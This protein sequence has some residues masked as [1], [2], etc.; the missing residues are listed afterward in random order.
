MEFNAQTTQLDRLDAAQRAAWVEDGFLIARQLFSA[1]EIAVL[2]ERAR[3]EL[4]GGAVMEKADAQGNVTKLKMWT[5]AGDD[6]FG[7]FCRNQR[8]VDLASGLLGEEIYLYSHKM[9]M[10]EPK[11]GGAWEWHQD[12]GYW[13]E[14]GCLAP[15]MLSIMVAVDAADRENGCLQVL[16]GSQRL[17]RLTHLRQREQ[18]V[19]DRER[20]EQALKRFPLVHVELAAGDAVVFH[21]NLL[22]ASDP[23]RSEQPRWAYICSYNTVANAPYKRVRDYGNYEPL[24]PLPRSSILSTAVALP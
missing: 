12:Y 2:R 18:T 1:D 21:C 13:H 7:A 22:H 19:T 15:D 8:M 9:T 20:V 11:V 6:L 10:K 24:V 14:Y 5:A 3:A 17:G 23:N 16:T 4:R